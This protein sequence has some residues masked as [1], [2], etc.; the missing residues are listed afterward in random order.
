MAGSSPLHSLP[1]HW[2][3]VTGG[4]AFGMVYMATDPVTAPVLRWAKYLYGILIGLLVILVRVL[5][6]AYVEGMMMAIV[7]AN[8]CA[9][10]MDYWFLRRNKK[11]RVLRNV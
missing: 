2:H 7:F 10:L 11:R 1:F 3:L 5:N 8:I 9:P 4:F 6:P